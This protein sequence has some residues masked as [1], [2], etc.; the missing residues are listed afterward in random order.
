M[1]GQMAHGMMSAEGS[2]AMGGGLRP[3]AALC[4]AV[5]AASALPGCATGSAGK[6]LTGG[7]TPSGATHCGKAHTAAGVPVEI[8]VQHGS[9]GCQ[10][11][12][13]IER[14]YAHQLASGKVPGNGGGAP[15]KIHGWICQGFN[16]PRVLSTGEA[17]ACRKDSMEILAVLPSPS[18]RPTSS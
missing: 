16:T 4:L 13:G 17:S 5:L 10:T 9:V 14:Q 15:V 3:V 8:E 18:A 1:P 7:A 2:P 12:L 6:Q 11:A